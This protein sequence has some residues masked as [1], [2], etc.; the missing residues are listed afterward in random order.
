MGRET[1]IGDSIDYR[2]LRKKTSI[3]SIEPESAQ[4]R[5]RRIVEYMTKKLGHPESANFYRKCAW[6][7]S[8]DEIYSRIEASEK[9]WVKNG[10]AYFI[11]SAHR[12]LL[13]RGK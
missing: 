7:L 1:R 12:L 6:H 3:E 4:H 8:E 11:A 13:K 5:V 2:S 9:P 10:H